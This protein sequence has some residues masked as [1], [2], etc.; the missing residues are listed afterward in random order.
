[1]ELLGNENLLR[2]VNALLARGTL[3]QCLLLAG[4]EG[5][6][7]SLLAD[8][9]TAALE[10][11]QPV[12]GRPCGACSECR[13]VQA[14]IHPDVTV[15]DSD[16]QTIPV[17]TVRR[18]QADAWILPNQGLRKVYRLPRADALGEAA[19]NALLKLVEEPPS[20]AVFL[21]E[22]CNPA[23]LLPTVRSRATELRMEPL[24]EAVL[25]RELA[26][27]RP[28]LDPARRSAAARR[29]EGWLGQA[30]ALAEENS[31]PEAEALLRALTQANPRAALLR[32]CVPLEKYKRE[33]LRPVLEQLLEGL[34]EA[35]ACRTGAQGDAAARKLGAAMTARGLARAVDAAQEALL[36]LQSNVSPGH[37]MGAL[38]VRLGAAAEP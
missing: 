3:A 4:P 20:Y 16:K 6:G 34:T 10:C 19:Q 14:G 38:S 12:Q 8:Y 13:R 1:M 7:K 23:L 31:S 30:L 27:R 32:A 36:H 26:A 24:P 11:R 17:E 29:S 28:E 25:L 21:L 5:S 9:L 35:L 18:M 15:V 22:S 33:Q 2:Q 37:I